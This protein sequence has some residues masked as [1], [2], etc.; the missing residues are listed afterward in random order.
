MA[1]TR[2]FIRRNAVN[3]FGTTSIYL[4]LC[5][6]DQQIDFSTNELIEP[7]YWDSRL[8]QVKK[9]TKGIQALITI[10]KNSNQ[11]RTT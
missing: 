11:K 10:C 6:N 3:R 2:L 9:A 5:H 8:Q 7:R 1:K 4:R